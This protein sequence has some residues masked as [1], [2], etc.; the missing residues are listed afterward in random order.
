MAITIL[1]LSLTTVF[2]SYVA[3]KLDSPT[4]KLAVLYAIQSTNDEGYRV[5]TVESI[6]FTKAR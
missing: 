6:D 1:Y 3:N 4:N 2:L 5:D